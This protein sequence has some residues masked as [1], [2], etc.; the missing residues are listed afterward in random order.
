MQNLSDEETE[1]DRFFLEIGRSAAQCRWPASRPTCSRTWRT[2][3][4]RSRPTRGRSRRRSRSRLD[5]VGVDPV[6][7]RA[8]AL[9]DRLRRSLAA[10][11]PRGAG[12]AALAAGGEQGLEGRHT[13][14]LPRTVEL[15][16]RLQSAFAEAEDLFENPNTLLA[17]RDLSTALTVTRPALEFIAPY[18]TVCNYFMYFGTRSARCSPWSRTAPPAAARC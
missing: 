16:E 12:A 10:A 9:H 7:P 1:L 11:P 15:N 18:Q 3:S 6:V 14:V 8:A 13:P 2:R 17:L 4:R 5:D